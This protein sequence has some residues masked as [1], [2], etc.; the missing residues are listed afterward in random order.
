MLT[1]G[2]GQPQEGRQRGRGQPHEGR[3][4]G[5]GQPLKGR[6]RGV[7]VAIIDFAVLVI[8]LSLFVRSDDYFKC[9]KHI[10]KA[11]VI[12]TYRGW[13]VP[14]PGRGVPWPPGAAYGV[15]MQVCA[16]FHSYF[17]YWCDQLS[18]A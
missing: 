7:C 3:Q 16:R 18:I 17:Y 6:Q 13:G 12:I 1:E 10:A 11:T 8:C 15:S 9:S 2:R 14:K 5:R 4:K